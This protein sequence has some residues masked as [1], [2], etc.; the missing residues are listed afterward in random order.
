LLGE[1]VD[2]HAGRRDL[3]LKGSGPTPFHGRVIRAALGP[4]L[5]EYIVSEAMAA[6]TSRPHVRW[7]RSPRGDGR[8]GHSSSGCCSHTGCGKPCSGRHVPVLCSAWRCGGA[9]RS[10]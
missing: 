1:V 8:T 7:Q 4:V 10:R 6:L 3:Q 9:S 5:R 2:G